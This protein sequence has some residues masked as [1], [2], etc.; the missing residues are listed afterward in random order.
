MGDYFEINVVLNGKHFFAT[1]PR[2]ITTFGEMVKA[3]D[4]F[5]EKFPKSEGYKISVTNYVTTG[6]FM[7]LDTLDELTD[8]YTR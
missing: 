3:Y 4:I 1:A 8:L 2:S 5:K 6:K 7:N